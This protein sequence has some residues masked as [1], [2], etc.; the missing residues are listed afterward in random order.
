MVKQGGLEGHL[1]EENARLQK[2][3]IN[4]QGSQHAFLQYLSSAVEVDASEIFQ[5]LVELA[6]LSVTEQYNTHLAE[7]ASQYRPELSA[8]ESTAK[9]WKRI[10]IYMDS[11][12][13][14]LLQSLAEHENVRESSF[15]RHLLTDFM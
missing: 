8:V 14:R 15:L 12:H 9:K 4:L 10:S 6:G 11:E 1:T 13:S 7:V 2:L 5:Q 3:R